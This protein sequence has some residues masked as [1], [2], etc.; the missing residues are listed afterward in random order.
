[1][2]DRKEQL[3]VVPVA[4]REPEIGRWLWAMEDA[5]QTTKEGLKDLPPTA[6]DWSFNEGSHS[7]G[8]L[9]YHIALVE[10]DWVAVEVLESRVPPELWDLTPYPSRDAEGKLTAVKGVTLD[11]HWQRLAT[12]RA[13]LLETYQPMDFADFHRPRPLE[14]YDVSPAWVLHHL[15]QHEAEH[16]DELLALK[17]GALKAL[18]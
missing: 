3:I 14:S 4:A 5:R 8:T 15:L 10:L 11:E 1:M 13:F 7:V 18:S 17:A 12:V 9:L 6:V 16:R 2:T